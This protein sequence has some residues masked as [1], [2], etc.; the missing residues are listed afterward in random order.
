M[1]RGVKQSKRRKRPPPPPAGGQEAAYA[2]SL[3]VAAKAVTTRVQEMHTAI[4]DKTFRAVQAVPGLSVPAGL[5]QRAHDAIAGGV[6]AAVRGGAT[7]AMRIAAEAERAF[8]DPARPAQ[9]REL[10]LRS[11]L[12]AAAGDALAAARSPLAVDMALHARG[13]VLDDTTPA[14]LWAGL[15]PRVAVFIHGLA[16]DERSW[17]LF[18]DA[19]ADV[20]PTETAPHYGAMLEREFS[21]IPLYL[22]YNTGLPLGDNA[23]GLAEQLNRL[24]ARA[25]QVRELVIVGH[26]MGGLVARLACDLAAD[27]D[28]VARVRWVACLGSPL[29]GAPLEKLGHFVAAALG[30]SDVTR[31]LQTIADSRSQGVKDLRHGLAALAHARPPLRLVAGSLGQEATTGSRLVRRVLG[32]GLVTTRSALDA[33]E[34][35]DV[36]R[37]EVPGLGHMALLN[38]PRV[39]ALLRQWLIDARSG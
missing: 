3:Q 38:H 34:A 23:A 13:D 7:V 6:Y 37:A 30:S 15:G 8:A 17:Q 33:R 32:D 25:P 12:N 11:A 1:G 21:L 28:W 39:Y 26:S 35:G 31:P 22:R 20:E 10:T 29:R 36:E 19:W 14:E 27:S 9:G 24:V 4:S 18:A 5:V 16:C 2:P